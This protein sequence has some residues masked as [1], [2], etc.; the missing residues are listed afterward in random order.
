MVT[1]RRQPLYRALCIT[2]QYI[3]VINFTFFYFLQQRSAKT[4]Q[5]RGFAHCD[6]VSRKLRETDT[7]AKI[8]A[9]SESLQ[10]KK[11]NIKLTEKQELFCQAKAAGQ[12][13]RDAALSAGF[14]A[15]SAGVTASRM[16]RKPAILSRISAL[17]HGTDLSA[18][19]RVS[20]VES[21]RDERQAH[22][23]RL[24]DLSELAR[25]KG[26]TSAAIRAE[27]LIGKVLGFYVE[28]QVALSVTQSIADA[29]PDEIKEALAEAMA[30]YGLG[31]NMVTD[32]KLIE[33]KPGFL[34]LSGDNS[35][36]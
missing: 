11:G 1:K 30:K 6:I 27:E 34:R 18:N 24:A 28:Q 20:L 36:P 23:K 5:L 31:N 10:A 8:D 33:E 9:K 15:A 2:L 4:Q 14:G 12:N 32:P 21:I 19:A 22:I 7:L 25:S 35:T 16:M 17:Q 3:I 26:Q 13:N 29:N